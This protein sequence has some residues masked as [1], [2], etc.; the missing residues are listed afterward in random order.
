[1][2][3]R[4]HPFD[5][6]CNSGG[7]YLDWLELCDTSTLFYSTCIGEY[8]MEATGG[9]AERAGGLDYCT[10]TS[11]SR[12]LIASALYVLPGHLMLIAYVNIRR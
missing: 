2:V 10:F 5:K 4:T 1:M 8:G 11:D 9:K 12:I 6:S 3:I 7:H